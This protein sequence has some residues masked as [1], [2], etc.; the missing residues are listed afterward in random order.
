MQGIALIIF[1]IIE[2]LIALFCNGERIA[3]SLFFW[4][5]I[6]PFAVFWTSHECYVILLVEIQISVET[7]LVYPGVKNLHLT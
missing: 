5:Q 6:M 4:I 7:E 3:N 2:L 1:I